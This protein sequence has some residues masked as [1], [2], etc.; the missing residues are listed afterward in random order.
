MARLKLFE[1]VGVE[2]E[3]MIVDAESLDVLP[4]ADKV[5]RG[6]ADEVV[7][8][9]ERGPVAWSNEIVNHVLEVKTNGPAQA[10][11]A[12]LAREFQQT[13]RDLNGILA[14]H[15]ARLLPTAAHPWMDPLRETILWPHDYSVVYQ[16]YDRI[17]GCQGHGWSNLQSVHINLPFANDDEFGRL[18][19]AIRLLLPILPAIAASSPIIEGAPT[20]FLDTRLEYY[21]T[22]SIR[23]PSITGGVIPEPVFTEAEYRKE[24]YERTWADI[25]PHDPD[26]VL[27]DE[28]LNSRGAIARFGRGAIEI[29][30][31]DLQEC[32]AQDIAVVSA[33][34]A[35]LK[36]LVSEQFCTYKE[37][38]AMASEPL[39]ELFLDCVRNGENATMKQ[40][41][42]LRALGMEWAPNHRVRDVW[43]N[44]MD[45]SDFAAGVDYEQHPLHAILQ[46]GTLA[47]RILKA[48]GEDPSRDRLMAI[49]RRLADCLHH[50]ETFLG[51]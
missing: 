45:Q 17:F 31:L 6:P 1:K 2:L 41:A 11:D 44:L 8:D 10:A 37:Q 24:I 49:Y 27:Q 36:A 18:H 20:G 47:R 25:A 7:N 21:R 15:G 9:I 16:A 50:G 19:A 34:V 22:N 28:F 14:Q 46:H 51:I 12:A 30:V 40:P 26:G 42:I 3:Y 29:R 32:P 43:M 38:R 4:I 13:V 39:R 33:I 48:R 23:I 5:L 35:V